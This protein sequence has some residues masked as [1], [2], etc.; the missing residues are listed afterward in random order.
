MAA[1]K[2]NRERHPEALRF[3]QKVIA[4]EPHNA[5]ALVKVGHHLTRLGRCEEAIE[6][7]ERAPQI[8]PSYSEA[9]A[10]LAVAYR[11]LGRNKEALESLNRGF[12]IKPELKSQVFWL[13]QLGSVCGRL[14]LWNES[15]EAFQGEAKL[16]PKDASAWEGIG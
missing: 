1:A 7:F 10:Y 13:S 9:H 6:F 2:R 8:S 11:Q 3:L 15:L 5:L 14:G 4:A 16:N 12:R